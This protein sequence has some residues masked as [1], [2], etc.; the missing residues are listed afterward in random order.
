MKPFALRVDDFSID[1]RG[2]G[3]MLERVS[4]NSRRGLSIGMVRVSV[5]GWQSEAMDTPA[6][7]L[8]MGG[9][10]NSTRHL[11]GDP[12]QLSGTAVL[13]IAHDLGALRK[14]ADRAILTNELPAL[15]VATLL[16]IGVAI[17]LATGLLFVGLDGQNQMSWG[18]M[19]GSNG[20]CVLP[21]WCTVTLLGAAIFVTV[22]EVSLISGGLNDAMN[23]KL[24]ERR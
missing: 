10:R 13:L 18:L 6:E 12:H 11:R 20:L 15:V 24:R 19:L 9:I 3:K 22:V 7:I 14:M 21:R 8:R 16:A 5:F 2:I 4:F 23:Q 1:F 17:L